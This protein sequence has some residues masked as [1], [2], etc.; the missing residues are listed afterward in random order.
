RRV[1]LDAIAALRVDARAAADRFLAHEQASAERY[2]A[3]ISLGI[4]EALA[5]MRAGADRISGGDP[6]TIA[7][8]EQTSS[9]VDWMQWAFWDLPPLAAILEPDPR[10]F[11]NLL[12]ACGLV[13]L[14]FRVIDDMLDRHYLYRGRRPTLLA[15]FTQSHGQGH[16]SEGLT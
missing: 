16:V 3:E 13:Y 4:N 12:T 14:S 6:L 2:R 9:Y 5:A 1:L 7:L 8:A 15:T 11:R 10:R